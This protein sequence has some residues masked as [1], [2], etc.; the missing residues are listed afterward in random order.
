MKKK[1]KI[2]ETGRITD[3]DWQIVERTNEN[4][5]ILYYLNKRFKGK[6]AGAIICNKKE[7]KNLKRFMAER[8]FN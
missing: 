8:K 5:L 2:G 4:G 3:F 7:L 6:T 1:L